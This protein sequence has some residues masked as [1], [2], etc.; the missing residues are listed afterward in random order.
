MRNTADVTG[1]KPIAVSSQCIS[2]MSAVNPLAAFYDIHGRKEE[3][4]FFYSFPDTSDTRETH[5]SRRGYLS[6]NL[7][8]FLI[9][10]KLSVY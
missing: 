2:D 8:F 9:C 6:H 1:G 10:M 4:L 3:V 7:I 5:L